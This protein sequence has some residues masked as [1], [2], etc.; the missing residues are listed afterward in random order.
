M[1]Q[2]NENTNNNNAQDDEN[3]NNNNAFQEYV[4][5]RL[6][7]SLDTLDALSNQIQHNPDMLT[8]DQLDLIA[9]IH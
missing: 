4:M 8:S 5:H 6:H 9:S 2:P 3:N 1:T 7:V